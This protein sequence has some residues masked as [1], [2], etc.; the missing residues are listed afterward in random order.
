MEFT[1]YGKKLAAAE[2]V[3]TFPEGGATASMKAAAHDAGLAIILTGVDADG[4]KFKSSA[5]S[6]IGAFFTMKAVWGLNNAWH[7]LD[8][9]SR[10]LV[11]RR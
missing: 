3:P 8:D 5:K 10:K 11:I 7:V 1:D 4:R 6:M 2:P 9:G